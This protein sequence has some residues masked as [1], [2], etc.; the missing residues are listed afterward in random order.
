MLHYLMEDVTPID[1]EYPN[2]AFFIQDGMALLN[3]PKNLPTI[4]GDIYLQVTD[5]MVAKKNVV[6]STDNYY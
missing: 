2:D 1:L 6:L 5:Q 3:V 4:F